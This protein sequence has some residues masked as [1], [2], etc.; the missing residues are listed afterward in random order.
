LRTK[1]G[2]TE[3]FL[4]CITAAG[5]VV[6]TVGSTG[7][8]AVSAEVGG[9]PCVNIKRNWNFVISELLSSSP[10]APRGSNMLSEARLR[11][12]PLPTLLHIQPNQYLQK[13][14]T[15][16]TPTATKNHYLYYF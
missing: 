1:R 9:T 13:A 3:T 7:C 5:G 4:T 10:I 12:V 2:K 11:L 16:P 15:A 8:S 6:D 14:I